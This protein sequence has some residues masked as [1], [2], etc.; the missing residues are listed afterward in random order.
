MGLI[1]RREI[2]E[3][4]T[5]NNEED[6]LFCLK[7]KVTLTFYIQIEE[8]KCATNFDKKHTN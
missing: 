3:G 2:D 5:T 8:V 4:E 1:Q 6:N 7:Y